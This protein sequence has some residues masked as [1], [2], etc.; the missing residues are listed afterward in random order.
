MS[1]TRKE[2]AMRALREAEAYISG[3]RDDVDGDAKTLMETLRGELQQAKAAPTALLLAL[4]ADEPCPATLFAPWASSKR[5]RQWR[6]SGKLSAVIK[7]GRTCVRPSEFFKFF[8]ALPDESR[9]KAGHTAG[10]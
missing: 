9:A 6:D 8:N 3:I 5:I 2:R 10:L 4:L 1:D 7:H